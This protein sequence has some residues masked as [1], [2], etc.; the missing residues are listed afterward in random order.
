MD[1][2]QRAENNFDNLIK[3]TYP[4]RGIIIGQTPDEQNIVQVYWTMGRSN[5]SKN[6]I[7]KIE[8]SYVKTEAFDASKLEDPSLIIYNCIAQFA[9]KHVVANGDQSDTVIDGIKQDKS[10]SD[11]LRTR[12]YEPDDPNCTPRITGL[13]DTE[14]DG[15]Q[16]SILKS[17][18]NTKE[19]H[20]KN[21][22][23]YEQYIPGYGH[24]IHT[25]FDDGTPLPS[26]DG[27]PGIVPLVDSQQENLDTYWNALNPEYRVSILVK[28]INKTSGNTSII[29]KN[30][31]V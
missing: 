1:L 5:N 3:K 16:L 27:D 10:F 13:V 22:Y 19:I 25:Y 6:R 21:F 29:M 9:N 15:Y 30:E 2:Q 14:K 18:Y 8:D 7:F 23:N 28:Y 20:S 17:V 31:L 11:A 12:E 4:G 26:F 24:L